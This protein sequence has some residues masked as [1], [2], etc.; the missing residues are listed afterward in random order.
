MSSTVGMRMPLLHVEQCRAMTRRRA[1]LRRAGRE[2]WLVRFDVAFQ[3]GMV[4][5]HHCAALNADD[6]LF[7]Q[8]AQ[9]M[10]D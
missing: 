5:H 4:E 10:V 8:V 1:A 3:C 6:I 7:G 2:A 9:R